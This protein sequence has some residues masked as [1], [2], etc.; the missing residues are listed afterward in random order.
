MYVFQ[1]CWSTVDCSELK[2]SIYAD[3]VFLVPTHEIVGLY[4]IYLEF[5][6]HIC[7]WHICSNSMVNRSCSLLFHL[8]IYAVMWSLY[9]YIYYGSSAEIQI[10]TT[11]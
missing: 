10:G 3:I 4:G 6:R 1:C 8:L 7:C 9:I 11:L 5:K 2:W